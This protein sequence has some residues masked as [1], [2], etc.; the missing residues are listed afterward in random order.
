MTEFSSG[1]SEFSWYYEGQYLP[2]VSNVPLSSAPSFLEI[3]WKRK[4][5]FLLLISCSTNLANPTDWPQQ[6]PSIGDPAGYVV[7]WQAGLKKPPD[8][9]SAFVAIDALHE[10][11][12]AQDHAATIAAWKKQEDAVA[13]ANACYEAELARARAEREGTPDLIPKEV[14]TPTLLEVNVMSRG[15]EELGDK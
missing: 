8:G 5:Y 12:N 3:E 7:G 1:Y 14:R 11:W 6:L 2:A 10:W 15:A 9:E 4:R 13:E